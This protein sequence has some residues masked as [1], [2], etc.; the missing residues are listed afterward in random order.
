MHSA[1]H[2]DKAS[3]TLMLDTLRKEITDLLEWFTMS[4]LIWLTECSALQHVQGQPNSAALMLDT[5][6]QDHRP[7]V[8]L[9][10]DCYD[11]S[12]AAC[13]ATCPSTAFQY[14]SDAGNFAEHQRLLLQILS[15]VFCQSKNSSH[16]RCNA[17]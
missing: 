15:N 8:I 11:C 13:T 10:R 6:Q 17:Q 7:G 4:L 9:C 16:M 14:H 3:S 5:L 12:V 1:G 2:E